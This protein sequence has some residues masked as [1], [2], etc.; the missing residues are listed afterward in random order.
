MNK[1][2]V[3]SIGYG[4]KTPE[5][6]VKKLKDAGVSTVLDV[7][8]SPRCGWNQMFSQNGLS[9]MLAKEHISY[10]HEK[11]LG[12]PKMK[13]ELFTM[14]QEA[15]DA[16]DEM[17]KFSKNAGI[18]VAL[19]CAEGNPDKCHRKALCRW[20]EKERDVEVIHL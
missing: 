6:L 7:R 16:L 13:L 20:L 18:K 10:A 11:R 15:M 1:M 3:F 17:F 8:Y 19:M 14:E 4:G 9:E 12:N 2:K 5:E